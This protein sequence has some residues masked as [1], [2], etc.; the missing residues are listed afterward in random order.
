M[1]PL[2]PRWHLLTTNPAV[3]FFQPAPEPSPSTPAHVHVRGRAV[4][5]AAQSTFTVTIDNVTVGVNASAGQGQYTDDQGRLQPGDVI[6]TVKQKP[7][8]R[9]VRKGDNLHLDLPITL[10]QALLGFTKTLVK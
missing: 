8:P 2:A 3:T 5:D 1:A 7:H 10:K 6:V 9:F 4:W